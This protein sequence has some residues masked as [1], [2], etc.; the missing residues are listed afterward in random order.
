MQTEQ[1]KPET[2]KKKGGRPQG[3][4]PKAATPSGPTPLE[5]DGDY[6]VIRVKKKE[7]AKLLLRDLI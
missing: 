4:S 3:Y 6:V 2:T 1:P 5:D 7:L